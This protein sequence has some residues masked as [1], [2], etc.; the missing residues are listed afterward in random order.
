MRMYWGMALTVIGVGIVDT[1]A[2]GVCLTVLASLL[3]WWRRF[4]LGTVFTLVPSYLGRLPLSLSWS[5]Q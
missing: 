5:R 1:L 2:V 4:A 3:G